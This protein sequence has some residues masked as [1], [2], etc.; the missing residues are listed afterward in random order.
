MLF[1]V[2]PL[3]L[4]SCPAVSLCVCFSILLFQYD[5]NSLCVLLCNN[6]RAF[7]CDYCCSVA[8]LCLTLCDPLDYSLPGDG[9][10]EGSLVC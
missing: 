9:E 8:Q 7:S 3:F 5:L 1:F 10:G 4:I 2:D 6:Y